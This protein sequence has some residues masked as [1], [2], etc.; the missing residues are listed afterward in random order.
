MSCAFLRQTMIVRIIECELCFFFFL[1]FSLSSPTQLLL[2]VIATRKRTRQRQLSDDRKLTV[3]LQPLSWES[4]EKTGNMFSNLRLKSNLF[5]FDV[6]ET[7]FCAYYIR[8]LVEK[9]CV[10]FFAYELNSKSHV[11]W[12]VKYW[13]S[14]F[15]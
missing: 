9:M 8:S 2:Y 12:E 10:Y 14:S 3:F 13:M 7:N 1:S 5:W 4:R 6:R 11:K 15:C